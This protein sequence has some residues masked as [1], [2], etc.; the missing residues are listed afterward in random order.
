MDRKGPECPGLRVIRG[1]FHVIANVNGVTQCTAWTAAYGSP[2]GPPQ[3]FL[4]EDGVV[5]RTL[6]QEL[7]A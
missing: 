3:A 1:T 6:N 2:A 4:P 7:G 5:E